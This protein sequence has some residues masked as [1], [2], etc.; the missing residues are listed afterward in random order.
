MVVYTKGKLELESQPCGLAHCCG[1]QRT[2]E[3]YPENEGISCG[4][5]NS[6]E[7][8]AGAYGSC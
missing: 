3:G 2:E 8:R 6:E 7:Q 1:S 4:R 5:D